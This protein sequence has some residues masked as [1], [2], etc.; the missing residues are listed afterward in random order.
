MSLRKRHLSV[1]WGLLLV[2]V[3]SAES[4]CRRAESK[5]VNGRSGSTTRSTMPAAARAKPAAKTG[6]EI[7]GKR[8]PVAAAL[9]IGTQDQGAVRLTLATAAV[10]CQTLSSEY[11]GRSSNFG[12]NR[13]DVWV[14][15]P[16][17]SDG[18]L[19]PW[20]Y[21]SGWLVD[22][23]SARPLVARGAQVDDV[24]VEAA[25]VRVQGLDL[26]LQDG[27]RE[28]YFTGDLIAKNCGRRPRPETKRPQKKIQLRIAGREQKVLGATIRTKG[29]LDILRLTA[30]AHDCAS[31][32][33]EGFDWYI[34]LAL[35]GVPP[36]LR[37]ATL[38]GDQFPDSV[39]GSRGRE[40]FAVKVEKPSAKS[41]EVDIS[42]SGKLDLSGFRTELNG[43]LT[44]LR[45]PVD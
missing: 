12:A 11:P 2:A 4:G 20:T 41:Q 14:A 8:I 36:M 37:F 38:Q 10:D 6:L 29:Q 13:I 9:A 5:P 27:Q 35:E 21:R 24:R 33:N 18:G 44:A 7:H 42:L 28:I 32:F 19:E 25:S 26:A 39:A 40:S 23:R 17:R 22:S 34:D 30:V 3:W 43:R 31:S 16:Q 15:R 45:C 1:T